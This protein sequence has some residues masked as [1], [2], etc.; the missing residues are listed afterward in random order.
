MS[1]PVLYEP[2][3]A[4]M[5]KPSGRGPGLVSDDLYAFGVSMVVL[6]AGGNPVADM[7]DRELVESKIVNGSYSTLVGQMRV[8]LSIMEPLRGLLCDDP[9]ERWTVADMELWL[10]G[11]QLSPKQPMLPPRASRAISF[12]GK[13]YWNRFSLSN[14]IGQNWE[15][16]ESILKTRELEGWV[17]RSYADDATAEAIG[18]AGGGETVNPER[19]VCRILTVLQPSLPIRFRDFS[20][21]IEG[22]AQC[23]AA[24]YHDSG[25]RN[26]LIE[27]FKAKLPQMYLHSTPGNR[28]EQAALMKIFDMINY[29]IDRSQIGFGPE[30]ALYESNR[31]WPCQSPLL[32]QEYV[33]EIE[34][35]LPALERV[36][37]RGASGDPM[38]RHI[39]AYCA[40]RMRD[41]SDRVLRLLAVREDVAAQRLATLKILAEAQ[42][43]SGGHRKFPAL[44]KWIG[45]LMEPVIQQFHNRAYRTQLTVALERAASKGDLLEVEFLLDNSDVQ[46]QDNEGY[47]KAQ[48][49]YANLAQAITWLEEGGLTSPSHVAEKGQQAATVIS[50]MV[51]GVLIVV[52]TLIY[53]I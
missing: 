40:A 51:S 37:Q 32:K 47:K 39:A 23:F 13:E 9:A 28:A 12:A 50:A 27:L 29:F 11:R 3:D 19:T 20:A 41:L 2:I 48:K 42:R 52:L 21:R 53:V 30:R 18:S 38:D 15:Q 5:A 45:E 6:L 44:T 26:T 31:G 36:A 46:T 25:T 17:R 35:L 43:S 14:A 22:V 24:E 10:G 16:L 7:S 8:S 33:C 4:G 49:E 34:D 1:Q